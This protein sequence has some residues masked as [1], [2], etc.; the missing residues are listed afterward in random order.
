[1]VCLE[2]FTD[3]WVK[4]ELNGVIGIIPASYLREYEAPADGS[5]NP[6]S[7]PSSPHEVRAKPTEPPNP[8]DEEKKLVRICVL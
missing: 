8:E 2:H 6:G 1:V 5:A 4:V 7:N 3:G